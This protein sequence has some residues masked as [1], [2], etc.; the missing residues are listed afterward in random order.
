[1]AKKSTKNSK[2]TAGAG[3]LA[4]LFIGVLSSCGKKR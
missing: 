2:S 4:A 3:I 1:M